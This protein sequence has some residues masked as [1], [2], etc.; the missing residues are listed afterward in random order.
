LGLSIVKQ[1]VELLGGEITLTS[2]TGHGSAFTVV[3]PLVVE[4]E[5]Q[6]V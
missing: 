6:T 4:Q 1:L 2:E 3:L 5:S